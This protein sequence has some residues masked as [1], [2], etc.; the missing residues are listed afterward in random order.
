M[1]KKMLAAALI[2]GSFGAGMIPS[3]ASAEVI[4]V[5]QAPPAPREEAIPSPRSGYVW[6]PGHWEWRHQRH[7][8]VRGAWLRDRPGY[9][10]HAP[11]WEEREGAWHMRAG[12]WERGNRD[13]D[14]DG[15]R[16]RDDSH[17]NNPNRH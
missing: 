15:V 17:P 6:T 4:V 16:N 10:Y 3:T 13:R 5:R 14:G 2:A 1:M 12:A 9:V 7:V 8:W 11:T